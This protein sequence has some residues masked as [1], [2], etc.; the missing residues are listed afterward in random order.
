MSRSRFRR[1]WSPFVGFGEVGENK[2]E[3]VGCGWI[4]REPPVAGLY[5]EVDSSGRDGFEGCLYVGV[6]PERIGVVL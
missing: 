5:G 2:S 3:I 6:L 4:L 1:I